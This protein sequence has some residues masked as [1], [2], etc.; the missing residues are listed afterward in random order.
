MFK[1][2]LSKLTIKYLMNTNYKRI[3]YDIFKDF[4]LKLLSNGSE[5]QTAMYVFFS[6]L[7][8]PY[9]YLK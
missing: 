2:G 4:C 7:H 1:Q 9:P 5:E 8:N 6:K 3:M